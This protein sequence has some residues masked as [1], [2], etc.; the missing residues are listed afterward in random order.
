[1]AQWTGYEVYRWI[2]PEGLVFG[3]ALLATLAC[4]GVMAAVRA[5][6]VSIWGAAVAGVASYLLALPITGT[7]R[8]Q[9]FGMVG[10][11]GVLWGCSL[12]RTSRHPL[13]WLP[14]LMLLW[15]N[16]HGSFLMGLV[17]LCVQ[18]VGKTLAVLAKQNRETSAPV[19]RYWW[20]VGLSLAAVCINPHGAMLLVHTIG[21]GHNEILHSISE[22]AALSSEK[23]LTLT[24]FIVSSV[25]GVAGFIVSPKRWEWSDVL[26]F[27]L[28]AIGT[29]SAIRM[30]VWWALAWPWIMSPYLAAWWEKDRSTTTETPADEKT[31]MQTVIAMGLV[32]TTLII[33]PGSHTIITGH[34]RG[35]AQS[36]GTGT[37]IYIADEM[38]RRQLTGKLFAPMDWAD[39]F[40]WKTNDRVKPLVYTHVHLLTPQVWHD[41][42][43]MAQGMPDWEA[44]ARKYE[45]SYVLAD[46]DPKRKSELAKLVMLASRGDHP[47]TRIVYQ[48]QRSILVELLPKN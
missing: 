42:W 13:I 9:L 30:L 35:V 22:W 26:L 28:F 25:L 43:R 14:C 36:H 17:V 24:L 38:V 18:A 39:Y 12:L 2:G 40:I 46:R 16:L 33:A 4:G 44:L 8:P 41:Y 31:A 48:D 34:E 45:L 20:A 27:V 47:S 23:K 37:P 32:F 3:H 29:I 10:F 7:I 1:L 11:A 19:A 21:F 15:A 6:G 5:R